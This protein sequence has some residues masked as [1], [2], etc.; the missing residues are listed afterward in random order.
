MKLIISLIGAPTDNARLIYAPRLRRMV[1][2]PEYRQ[3]FND[4]L[5][6]LAPKRPK[7]PL[8]ASFECQ[9]PY[10]VKIWLKDKR[11]DQMNY[12]KGLRDVLTKA[13]IWQDDKWWYGVM[14]PCEISPRNPRAEIIIE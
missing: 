8:L 10:K 6:V 5:R 13:K 11:S 4:S 1:L 9:R 7:T 2:S 3:W 14:E 12:D